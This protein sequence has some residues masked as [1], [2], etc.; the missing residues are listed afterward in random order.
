MGNRIFK[1][2]LNRKIENFVLTFVEDSKSIFFDDKKLIHPGEYGRF[3]EKSLKDLLS[4]ITNHKISDGFII[5]PNDKVSTQL[6]IVIYKNNE[7][8]LLENN[9]T[10]FFSIES[11]VAIGEVKSTLSKSELQK[12]L[13]KLAENKKFNENK[14]GIPSDGLTKWIKEDD[15][16]VSFLVCKDLTFD[17]STLNF[18]EI[19]KDI[20]GKYWHNFILVIENG[21]ISYEF[22]TNSFTPED[23][24]VFELSNGN[25]NSTF[26]HGYPNFG[27][28][29]NIYKTKSILHGIDENDKYKHINIFIRELAFNL[30]RKRLYNTDFLHYLD[31]P[32]SK[33]FKD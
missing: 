22:E 9:Y 20:E 27:F 32:V 25:L 19:Y 13:L 31:L 7:A 23:R 3:R 6:D 33:V 10:D 14:M 12:A 8:P 29:N 24:N 15:E 28:N 18:D 2:V 30:E 16:V 5:T 11:V 17:I 21:L 26:W 4:Y 1:T